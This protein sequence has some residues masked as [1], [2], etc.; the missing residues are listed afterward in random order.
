MI[1]LSRKTDIIW[2]QK[3]LPHLTPSNDPMREF[4]KPWRRKLGV[5]TLGLA[6]AAIGGWIRSFFIT[7]YVQFG[8]NAEFSVNSADRL[9]F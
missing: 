5:A 3:D 1:S 2:R 4:F 6:L 8:R 9:E 7:D